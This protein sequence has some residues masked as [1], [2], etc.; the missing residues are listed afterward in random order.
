MPILRNGLFATTVTI[1]YTHL[2]ICMERGHTNT[3]LKLKILFLKN[4]QNINNH[5]MQNCYKS[6]QKS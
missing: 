4:I 6:L 2:L 1:F 5:Q 3:K